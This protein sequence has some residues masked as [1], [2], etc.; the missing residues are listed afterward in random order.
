MTMAKGIASGVPL[1]CIAYTSALSKHWLK[2]S[3]G[4]T[5]GGNALAC[6]AAAATVRVIREGKLAENAAARG[7][8]LME[9]LRA[10]QREFGQIG[11]VRGRGLMVATEF[12]TGREPDEAAAKAASKA[13]AEQG[14][15]L[16][17]CGTFDNVVRWIPPLVVNGEQI[18]EALGLFRNALQR[19]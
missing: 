8:Q 19:L 9:G 14:L 1:S 4:G 5:F 6:A 16:L 10:I 13:A 7:A 12:T 15:L 2:G 11:E 17:T 18:E 3:H